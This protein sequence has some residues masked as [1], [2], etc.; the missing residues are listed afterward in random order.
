M[1]ENKLGKNR[2]PNNGAGRPKG[3][4]NLATKEIKDMII[5]ALS[6]VGGQAYLARKAE[7]NP[8]AFMGLIG[9]VLPKDINANVESKNV[10]IV[11]D[12][13]DEKI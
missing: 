6:D 8:V 11:L 2:K 12:S 5:G 7:Q 13:Y 1:N 4:K 10:T 9:K 3:A